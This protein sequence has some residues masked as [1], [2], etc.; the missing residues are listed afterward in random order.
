MSCV[1]PLSLPYPA[2]LRTQLDV[3]GELSEVAED[4]LNAEVSDR[5]VGSVLLARGVHALERAIDTGRYFRARDGMKMLPSA[6]WKSEDP[7]PCV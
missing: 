4:V 5:P 6:W 2:K 1:P 3:N 7:G